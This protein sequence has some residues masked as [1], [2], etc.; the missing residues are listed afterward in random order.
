MN[1][2]IQTFLLAMTPV[3]ELRAAIPVAMYNFYLSWQVAYIVSVV[4]NLIPVV[5]LLLFLEPVSIFLSRHFEIFRKFFDWL[6]ARTRK[7]ANH[8]MQ[9]YGYPALVLFVAVPLPVTGAWTGSLVAFLFKIPFKK[10]FPLIAA[11]VAIAGVIVTVVTKAG[12]GLEK[13]L[14]LQALLILTLAIGLGWL[15]YQRTRKNPNKI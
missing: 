6:F 11:G 9:K 8:K 10:A 4:G 3:G 7:R 5:F 2:I 14:G 13:Y 1:G 12:S 15:F